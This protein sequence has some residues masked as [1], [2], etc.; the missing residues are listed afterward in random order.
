MGTSIAR[1]GKS[2]EVSSSEQ[3][4][5]NAENGIRS[6]SSNFLANDFTNIA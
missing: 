2:Q 3:P 4:E 6:I 1:I 5:R